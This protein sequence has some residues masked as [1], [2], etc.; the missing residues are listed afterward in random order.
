VLLVVLL[1]IVAV[2]VAQSPAPE[3]ATTITV[4]HSG[5]DYNDGYSTKCS[6]VNPFECTLRRAINEAYGAGDRPVYINFDIPTS[7]PGYDS[8]LGVWKIT[9]TGS[10]LYDLRELNGQTFLDGTTQPGGRSDGPKIIV[11]G[12]GSKNNGLIL[13]NN[14]NTVQGLAMQNFLNS[15]ITLSS[16]GNLIKDCWF[17]LSDDGTTLSSGDNTS[18]EGGSGVALATG[19]DNNTI[20]DNVFAGFFGTA[21]AIRG[22]NNRFVGNRVG[23]RANGTVP[24]PVQF[25][26]H[27]CVSGAWTGGVGITVADDDNQI[28]GPTAADG[29]VFAGLFLDVAPGTTQRPAMDVSGDG[30]LIQNNVIGLDA[31]GDLTGVCGRGLDFGN[32]PAGMQVLENTIV[33][34]GLSAIL[35]N[36]STLNGN[37]LQGNLIWRDSPWPDEQEFNTFPEDAIAYGAWVPSALKTFRP[38]R[39]TDVTGTAVTGTAGQGS[40]CPLC[41]VEI[42]LDNTNGVTETL[43]SLDLVTANASGIWNATLPAP[44][45]LGQGLRT[46]STVPD[47]FTIIGL[48]TGTTSNLSTLQA[49]TYPLF[50]PLIVLDD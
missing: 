33:E 47:D 19:S 49:A 48:D 14:D 16:D 41:T 20:R 1:A 31:N 12:Q 46:M 39:I 43:E 45:E 34:P 32:A 22:S 7:D 10:T 11:D 35:M 38:A 4:N 25:D 27:P 23:T 42:F 13:R 28:G 3:L 24:I 50:L 2:A 17:G 8:V 30:H 15:H 5:D 36:G 26:K 9:L 6:D 37:T 29:N 40:P 21:A 44:L 18:P